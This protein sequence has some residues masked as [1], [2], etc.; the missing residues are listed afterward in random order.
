MNFKEDP[1]YK[2]QEIEANIFAAQLLVPEQILLELQR[3][4]KQLTPAFLEERFDV[5]N[6]TAIIQLKNLRKSVY[7]KDYEKEFDDLILLKYAKILNKII[8]LEQSAY[9][10][11]Y[12]NY[13][14]QTERDSWSV[15]ERTRWD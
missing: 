5:S 11:D 10:N 4:G 6:D 13:R 1:E 3:R 14:L 8:P 12:N 7:R 15:D 2:E 9:F